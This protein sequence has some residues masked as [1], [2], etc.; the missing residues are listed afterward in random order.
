MS[1]DVMK[2]PKIMVLF[3]VSHKQTFSCLAIGKKAKTRKKI[4]FLVDF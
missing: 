3:T 4:I 1:K 2:T